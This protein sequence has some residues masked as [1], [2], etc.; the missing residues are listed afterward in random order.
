MPLKVMRWTLSRTT[1]AEWQ[2]GSMAIKA[3]IFLASSMCR[4]S[5]YPEFRCPHF[6]FLA[7]REPPT[8]FQRAREP[9]RREN[10]H[11]LPNACN[12]GGSISQNSSLYKMPSVMPEDFANTTQMY[13]T[14]SAV[15]SSR[16]RRMNVIAIT[17]NPNRNRAM[18]FSK[19]APRASPCGVLGA[20]LSCLPTSPSPSPSPS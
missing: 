2:L 1:L 20:R 15:A 16:G 6:T 5:G 14:R 13:N 19:S 8:A 18:V 11:R 3:V 10:H 17:A 4:S 12:D 7:A 9:R